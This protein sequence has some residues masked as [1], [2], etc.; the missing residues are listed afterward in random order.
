[1]RRPSREKRE[2]TPKHGALLRESSKEEKNLGRKSEER[3]SKGEE[4]MPLKM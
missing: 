4:L 1:V 3:V 2:S